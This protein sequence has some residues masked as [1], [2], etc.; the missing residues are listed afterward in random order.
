MS[1]VARGVLVG[2]VMEIGAARRLSERIRLTAHS[3]REN[4]ARLQVLV[5]E[6]QAGQAHMAL[7]YASWTAYL[8]DVFGE[9]PLRLPRDQRQE[10]VGYLAGEGMSVR[11]I[12]PI[13]G[14]SKSAVDRDRQVSQ[15]GT[16][17]PQTPASIISPGEPVSRDVGA[18]QPVNTET[19]EV[20][21][22]YPEAPTAHRP[23]SGEGP[24]PSPAVGQGGPVTARPTVTGRA[25]K[26]MRFIRV[27]SPAGG[28]VPIPD[29][30]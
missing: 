8:A 29:P 15:N 14:A 22:D 27:N 23:G 11:A 21:D 28:L 12:A 6:A 7:G 24:K 2:V 17:A 5:Q 10:L 26:T 19:G 30:H 1:E 3:A 4:L 9:E 18:G 13:V 25:G 20:S 16:P